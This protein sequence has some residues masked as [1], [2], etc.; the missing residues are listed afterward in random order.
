M[1]ARSIRK[2]E[3]SF[4]I[5]FGHIKRSFSLKQYFIFN[6]HKC[7]RNQETFNICIEFLITITLGNDNCT[8]ISLTCD[9]PA[10]Y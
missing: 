4:V 3:T 1:K 10:L 8:L 7:N 2:V 9:T 6:L 5:K